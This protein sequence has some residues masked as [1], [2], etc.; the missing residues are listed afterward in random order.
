[1]LRTKKTLGSGKNK[2]PSFMFN[3]SQLTA[4]MKKVKNRS[5]PKTGTNCLSRHWGSRKMKCGESFRSCMTFIKVARISLDSSRSPCQNVFSKNLIPASTPSRTC[6]NLADSV[7]SVQ[8]GGY[9]DCRQSR[10]GDQQLHLIITTLVQL[11]EPPR[12][13]KIGILACMRK[14][15]IWRRSMRNLKPRR[16]TPI[17]PVDASSPG[18]SW[19]TKKW[20]FTK[21][22]KP[23]TSRHN[24]RFT[25]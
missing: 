8:L 19:L 9:P 2:K 18:R 1:M 17:A 5:G 15:L 3:K 7:S 24:W 25:S 23:V 14:I 22:L 20:R 12:H 4:R 16:M 11:M 10:W 13:R 6:Q 21:F